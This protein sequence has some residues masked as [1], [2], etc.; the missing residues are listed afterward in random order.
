MCSFTMGNID[1]LDQTQIASR[2]GREIDCKRLDPHRLR[3][4][5]PFQR[6]HADFGAI[7]QPISCPSN[8]I[9]KR[10][11]SLPLNCA[12]FFNAAPR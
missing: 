4:D 8:E 6:F 9:M 7:C 3:T 10:G 1:V 12:Y 5:M 2:R 11:D